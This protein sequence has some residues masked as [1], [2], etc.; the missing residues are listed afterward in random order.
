MQS[1]KFKRRKKKREEA[2]QP[3]STHRTTGKGH[4][5]QAVR[6]RRAH[7]KANARPAKGPTTASLPSACREEIE[8]GKRERMAAA[9]VRV[10]IAGGCAGGRG[11][12]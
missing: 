11:L 7:R 1:E 6:R 12:L 5:G 9:M 10:A 3:A 8:K 2:T 4:R